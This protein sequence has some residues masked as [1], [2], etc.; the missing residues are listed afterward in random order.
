[1]P[2][3]SDHEKR[4]RKAFA[5]PETGVFQRIQ[6]TATTLLEDLD[7]L[8]EAHGLTT[9]QYDALR[10]LFEAGD[11]GLPSRGVG[12]RMMSRA[13]DVTRLLDRLEG[14]GLVERERDDEDRR[15]VRARLTAMGHEVLARVA[16]PVASLHREQ[17]G[18]MSVRSLEKLSMLLDKAWQA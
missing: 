12:Q 6:R 3:R 14:Q 18:H 4:L 10:V 2:S 1:M 5:G 15:V 9:P 13:P 8:L 16:E 7:G 11:A 17:L